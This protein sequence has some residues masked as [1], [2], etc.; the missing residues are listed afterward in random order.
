[1]RAIISQFRATREKIFFGCAS[2]DSGTAS[3]RNVGRVSACV[4][5]TRRFRR[6]KSSVTDA[7]RLAGGQDCRVP[8]NQSKMSAGIAAAGLLGEFHEGDISRLSM[9]HAEIACA[10]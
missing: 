8:L 2:V 1:M 6:W 9:P 5:E 7:R 3:P 4:L 10:C